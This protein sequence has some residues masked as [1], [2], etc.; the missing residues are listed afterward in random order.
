VSDVPLPGP[1]AP[2]R[3]QLVATPNPFRTG[4]A[5]AFALPAAGDV[6]LAVFDLSGRLVRTLHDGRLDAG[7]HRIEWD[8]R[9]AGGH[10]AAGGIYFVRLKSAAG[11][12]GTRVVKVN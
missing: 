10:A 3:L 8:G 9:D 11:E 12:A 2:A 6:D 7:T 1:P 5:I 4:A